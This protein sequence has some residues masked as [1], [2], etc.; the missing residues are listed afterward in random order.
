MIG[1]DVVWYQKEIK[2]TR[3]AIHPLLDELNYMPGCI[4][5][6]H[7]S[8]LD[9]IRILKICAMLGVTVRID[10][11]EVPAHELDLED[12]DWKLFNKLICLAYEA[13]GSIE[14]NVEIPRSSI[15]IEDE[16]LDEIIYGGDEDGRTV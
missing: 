14:F 9:K 4:L 5:S 3:I 15:S 11:V 16:E 8:D 7:V 10:D 1:E 6:K 2:S 12:I 13:I